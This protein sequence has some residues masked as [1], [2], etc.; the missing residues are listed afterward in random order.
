MNLSF[1]GLFSSF[2]GN[3]PFF[4]F[5][6]RDTDMSCLRNIPTSS[7]DKDWKKNFFYID[8]GVI[9]GEMHWREM[10]AKDMVPQKMLMWPMLFTQDYVGV[11]SCAR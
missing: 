7:K 2:Y 3:S 9:P 10:G 5:D 6:R 11:L 1:L 8:V 4:T